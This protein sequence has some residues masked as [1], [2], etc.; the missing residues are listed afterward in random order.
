MT[1]LIIQLSSLVGKLSA[2]GLTIEQREII[3]REIQ[4]LIIDYFQEQKKKRVD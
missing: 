4:I 3:L 1:V 2:S